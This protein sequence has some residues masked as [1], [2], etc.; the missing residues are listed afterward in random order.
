MSGQGPTS[1]GSHPMFLGWDSQYCKSDFCSRPSIWGKHHRLAT[2]AKWRTLSF[3]P[4]NWLLTSR[5]GCFFGVALVETQKPWVRGDLA[6]FLFNHQCPQ[7]NCTIH[8]I[9][10]GSVPGYLDHTLPLFYSFV[11]GKHFVSGFIPNPL[12]ADSRWSLQLRDCC[13]KNAGSMKR[14]AQ[15]ERRCRW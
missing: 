9:D 13:H 12:T 15:T 5:L 10:N 6:P 11:H 2:N 4:T 3:D 8:G 1:G 7:C 14:A